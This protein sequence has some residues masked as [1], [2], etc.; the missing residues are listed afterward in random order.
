MRI[1]SM[2]SASA[3]RAERPR[4]LVHCS[5]LNRAEP[6]EGVPYRWQDGLAAYPNAVLGCSPPAQAAV[7]VAVTEVDAA[8][9]L[10]RGSAGKLAALVGVENLRAPTGSLLKHRQAEWRVRGVG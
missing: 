5:H 1:F 10:H 3:S 9:G 7:F 6:A 4:W 2:D 8:R